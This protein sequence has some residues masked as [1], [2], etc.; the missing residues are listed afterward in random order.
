[1]AALKAVLAGVRTSVVY[2]FMGWD[3]T[4]GQVR[5][6]IMEQNLN[7]LTAPVYAEKYTFGIREV[8]ILV[9]NRTFRNAPL[10]TA[11]LVPDDIMP[12]SMQASSEG[13]TVWMN[14]P[15]DGKKYHLVLSPTQE[16]YLR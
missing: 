14:L 11:T 10:G 16:V 12:H 7:S 8:E 5:A 2:H 15:V 13:T 1:M 3:T 6:T 4:D 9:P